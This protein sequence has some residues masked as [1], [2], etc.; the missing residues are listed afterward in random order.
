MYERFYNLQERAFELT[1]NPRFLFL[2]DRHQEALTHVQYGI[3]GRKGVTLLTG[4][5]GLGKTSVI[6]AAVDREHARSANTVYLSNPRLTRDE[7]FTF[8]ALGF[9]LSDE[10]A[11][12]KS[13]FILEL[14]RLA[15]D[16]HAMGIVTALVVDEAQG[17]S[18]DL[19]EEI[20]L[21]MNLETAAEKLMS[22]LLVGQPPLADRLNEARLAPLKQR[23]ALRAVL[24]PLNRDETVAY[25]RHRIAVAGGDCSRIFTDAAVA[26]IYEHSAGVPGTIN[27][28]CDNALVAGFALERAPADR[29][30][31]LEVCEEFAFASLRGGLDRS[32]VQVA[33]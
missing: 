31:V 28:I 12:S 20:R 5:A 17:L 4:E 27:V 1:P 21:L 16:R 25:I 29:D 10:A 30:I 2:S 33:S 26:A 19:L 7:F 22:V 23:V 9:S 6:Y 8:L 15:V 13:R 24:T 14:S 11:A 18:D 3:T 32:E